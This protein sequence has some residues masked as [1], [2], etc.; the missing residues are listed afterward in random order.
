MTTRRYQIAITTG[1]CARQTTGFVINVNLHCRS[2]MPVAGPDRQGISCSAH[3]AAG[4]SWIVK[5]KYGCQ[6]RGRHINSVTL[7]Q[8]AAWMRRDRSYEPPRA[9]PNHRGG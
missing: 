5:G 4:W 8:N 6:V 7:L 3:V 2:A 1:C 9:T